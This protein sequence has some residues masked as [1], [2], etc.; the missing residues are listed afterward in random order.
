MQQQ[1]PF[2]II[3]HNP[4]TI[5]EAREFLHNGANALEPDIVYAENHY[6]VSHNKLPSYEDCV[7]VEVYLQQ[8]KALLLEKKYDLA[9]IIWDIKT[10]NFDPNHFIGIVKENFRGNPFEHVAMLMT[11]ADDHNF[12]KPVPRQF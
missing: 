12:C 7:T 5:D 4:N 1:R 3:G 6:Y 8:L 2:Y 9:L 10:T 11:N